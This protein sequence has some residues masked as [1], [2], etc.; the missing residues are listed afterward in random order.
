MEIIDERE[1]LE[2]F[3]DNNILEIVKKIGGIKQFIHNDEEKRVDRYIIVQKMITNV[4]S[5]IDSLIEKYGNSA[6]KLLGGEFDTFLY[7][8]SPLFLIL[9]F[10]YSLSFNLYVLLSEEEKKKCEELIEYARTLKFK[11]CFDKNWH[12]NE[13]IAKAIYTGDATCHAMR[14]DYDISYEKRKDGEIIYDRYNST[15]RAYKHFFSSDEYSVEDYHLYYDYESYPELICDDIWC[16]WVTN[17]S[18]EYGTWRLNQSDSKIVL[19]REQEEKLVSDYQKLCEYKHTQEINQKRELI[20]ATVVPYLEDKSFRDFTVISKLPWEE[21]NFKDIDYYLTQIFLQFDK[22]RI[23]NKDL[24]FKDALVDENFI[25]AIIGDVYSIDSLNYKVR[26]LISK[27]ISDYY[28]RNIKKE[29]NQG[30]IFNMIERLPLN[31]LFEYYGKLKSNFF[32]R[33]NLNRALKELQKS[34]N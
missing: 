26:K 23:D 17:R 24:T 27:Q 10:L 19:F 16:C 20:L 29:E 22:Y 2:I 18:Y 1:E 13:K 7:R 8:E 15:I 30:K 28:I 11:D 31:E 12:V 6:E 34:G 3:L 33:M 25:K 32:N 14:F 5:Y 9:D 21:E 4:F